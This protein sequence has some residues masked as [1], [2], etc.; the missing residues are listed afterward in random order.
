MKSEGA[1]LG[2]LTGITCTL[3][4][5]RT[6]ADCAGQIRLAPVSSPNFEFRRA[7]LLEV[8]RGCQHGK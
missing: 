5:E 2:I 1:R 6:V 3:W 8:I 7:A 4:R